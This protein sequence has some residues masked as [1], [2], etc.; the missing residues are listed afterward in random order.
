[1]HVCPSVRLGVVIFRALYLGGYDIVKHSLDLGRDSPVLTRLVAAQALTLVV[2]SACFPIDTV[3]RRLMVQRKLVNKTAASAGAASA[4][5]GAAAAAGGVA[6]AQ[7]AALKAAEAIAIAPYRNGW[8][9]LR[10]ILR[11]EGVKGLYSGLS[12][13]VV[14]S[15]SGAVLLVAY[16][17]I[18]NFVQP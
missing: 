11:E 4:S 9:C 8:D 16:D 7:S 10:R 1:V 12:V 2:G 3:K 18:K 5:A 14:R 13:N 15:L 6:S 17:E